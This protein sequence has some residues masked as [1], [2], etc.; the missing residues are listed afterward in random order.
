MF[1]FLDRLSI[2]N[3]IWAMVAFFVVSLF[4]SSLIDI[5]S[6][7]KLLFSEKQVKTRHL[8]ESAHSV[9]THFHD[10]QIKGVMAE[11]AA[12]S[13]AIATLR[14]M[15]Y[16]GKE[17]FWLNDFSTP[18]PKMIM[19]PTVPALDGKP[20]DAERFNCATS[21]QAGLD[22]PVVETDGKK[23]LFVAFNEVANHGGHGFVNYNWP[24]PRAGGGT[25]EEL[26]PKLS[27]VKKFEPWGMLVGSGVYID[28]IKQAVWDQALRNLIVVGGLGSFLLLLASVF[29]GSITRPLRAA[30]AAMRDIA[31]GEGDLTR[32]LPE[33]GN[34]EI[35]HLSGSY[36][37]FAAKIQQAVLHVT[38]AAHRLSSYSSK[39]S[40]VAEA[41]GKSVRQQDHETTAVAEAVQSML[42]A[43]REVTKSV[44]CAVEAARQADL[45][46]SAGKKVV[47]ETIDAINSVAAEV[48]LAGEVIHQ[49]EDD[50]RNI[51]TIIETIKG[52]ADQTNLLALNAAIEAARAGE[53]G[54][55]FAVV[56][57]EVRK[58]SQS[59]QEATRC[60]QDMIVRLQGNAKDAVRVME[61][62]RLRVVSSVEQAGRAGESLEQ[63]TL[64]VSTINGTNSEIAQSTAAQS[65]A[66]Q[67]I[68]RSIA[69]IKS[70][71]AETAAGVNDTESAVADLA[72][73]LSDLEGL[74][75]Q[76]KVGDKKL[77]LSAAKSAH[78]N[79]KTR[80]RAFLDGRAVLTEAEAVSHQHCAFG[81][82]YYSEGLSN[83]GH[84]Q[85]LRDVE[86]PHTELHSLI[87]DIVRL[88]NAGDRIQS[89]RLYEKVDAI[90]SRIV[91]LLDAA[92]NKA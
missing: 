13:A 14:T 60:I 87:K 18:Y 42:I 79:W 19:H 23:N 77:D 81:K 89:E 32:R 62:G 21:L 46:A 39:L 35:A 86:G 41:T 75:G 58:L 56:A 48:G 22:G 52:I 36:N 85:E 76:F 67:N 2:R 57:D 51:G 30:A 71:A 43:E 26:F 55:G 61:E 37:R 68:S 15:R 74:V 1:G 27:Y 54:R 10:Q 50:S 28:D 73:L 91:R 31:E 40:S 38:Q 59:T 80:L 33:E 12:R 88:K 24:K 25:T 20:L 78:L 66:T 92:E 72:R 84:I 64:S 69:T 47:R 49:L 82:W 70:M 65:G 90:S 63:I 29:A 53:Q 4:G 5:F 16:E 3:K 6:M 17:Y 11:E 34:N 44:D 83:F 9:L 45:E 8:V 7:E